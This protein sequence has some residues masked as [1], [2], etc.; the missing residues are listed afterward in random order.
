MVSGI[1]YWGAH[2]LFLGTNG[3][4]VVFVSA[5]QAPVILGNALGSGVLVFTG[6]GCWV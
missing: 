5:K 2:S 4:L 1:G 6:P 3:R